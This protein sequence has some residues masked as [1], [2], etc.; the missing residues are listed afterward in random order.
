METAK[1]DTPIG[2]LTIFVAA[3]RLCGLAFEEQPEALRRQLERQFGS[4]E[5][6]PRRDPGGVLSRL[7]A[8]FA[9]E[10]SALDGIVTDVRGTTFQRR[11]WNALTRIPVGATWSYA[12]LAAEIGAPAAV[13]A[14]GAANGRNPIA[15]VIPCHRVIASD[16]TLCGYGGGLDR[17]RWLLQHEGVWFERAAA[18]PRSRQAAL[19]F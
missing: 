15:I 4:P 7:R 10:L 11:V 5:L 9:G 13:R 3:G 16:G 12:Q 19:A 2:E 8:Y 18:R 17:K 14:V 6:R 1:L